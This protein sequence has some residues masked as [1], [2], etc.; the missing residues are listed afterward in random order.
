MPTEIEASV[1]D[2]SLPE[3]DERFHVDSPEAASWLVRRSVSA[4]EY[5]RRVELWAA[6]EIRRAEREEAFYLGRFGTELEIWARE[7]LKSIRNRKSIKL[8]GGTIGLRVQPQR[9][10]A[11]R[12]HL[13]GHW[14][15]AL[16][17]SK[18]VDGSGDSGA[19]G[20]R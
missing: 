1:R 19:W 11:C 6:G 7:Q 15:G 16:L 5:K 9:P 13:A 18:R 10:S 20:R 4:R 3:V 8:P 14:S 17:S 12:T 2:D